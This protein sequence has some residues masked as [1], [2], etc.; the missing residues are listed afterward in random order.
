M[1]IESASKRDLSTP[2]DEVVRGFVPDPSDSPALRRALLKLDAFL[3][4]IATLIY[5]LNFLD[6]YVAFSSY[7]LLEHG[8][9]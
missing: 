7:R 2:D 1:G 4:P 8:A 9:Q 5:F 6:R 3:L